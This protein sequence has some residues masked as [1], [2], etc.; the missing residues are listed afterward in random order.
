MPRLVGSCALSLIA[1]TCSLAAEAASIV[2]KFTLSIT[3]A[4]LFDLVDE[5]E[6]ASAKDAT[7]LHFGDVFNGQ[8]AIDL[9]VAGVNAAVH[10]LKF[11]QQPEAMAGDFQE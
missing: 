1:L 11:A 8:V 5:R 4:P 3:E 7:E 10:I 9:S 6:T 2:F